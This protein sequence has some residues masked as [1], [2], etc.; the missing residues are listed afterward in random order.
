MK[1]PFAG[2]ER[3]LGIH[4]LVAVAMA[5][6]ISLA[7]TSSGHAA[8]MALVDMGTASSGSTAPDVN[9]NYWNT[10]NALNQG[11]TVALVSI[12]N[13]AT[14]WS[15]LWDE[16]NPDASSAF[17]G[18]AFTPGTPP[19][20]PYNILPAYKDD[21]WD[22]V[23]GGSYGQATITGLDDLTSYTFEFYGGRPTVTGLGLIEFTTG[24]AV[25]GNTINL[26]NQTLVTAQATPSGGQ[27]VFRFDSASAT[28]GYNASFGLFSITQV[29]EP[30]T[31]SLAALGLMVLVFRRRLGR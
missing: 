26:P 20:A 17:G 15:L 25:G 23:R 19:P 4:F 2:S 9:G 29:P 13:A 16:I 3:T 1:I 14:G 22:G 6:V 8:D 28:G 7:S 30:A 31:L 10:R 12:N 5:G 24:T 11:A 27:L 21:W 18:V